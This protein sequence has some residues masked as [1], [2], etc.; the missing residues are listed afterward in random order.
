M[1][2]I[3]VVEDEDILRMLVV[4]ELH[5]SGFSVLEAPNGDIA[6]EILR[7]RTDVSVLLSDVKMPGTDGYALAEAALSLNPKMKIL[8]MTGYSAEPRPRKLAERN[9]EILHK[10]FDLDLLADK[11]RMLEMSLRPSA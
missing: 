10:P 4:E 8:L 3:L 6:L 9:I 7:G 2:Q 11:V 5:S 1:G